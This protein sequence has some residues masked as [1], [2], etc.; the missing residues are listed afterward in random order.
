MPILNPS[1]QAQI[2]P[3]TG[4]PYSKEDL[5]IQDRYKSSLVNKA[6]LSP[7]DTRFSTG[8]TMTLESP[9]ELASYT[10]RGVTLQV[11]GSNEEVRAENQGALEQLGYGTAKMVGLAGTTF[12]DGVLG[13]V[14]GLGSLVTGG[15]FVD[16]PFSNAMLDANEWMEKE[17]PNYYTAEG[18]NAFSGIVPFTQGSANFWGDKILKNFGFALGAYASGLVTAGLSE[19]MLGSKLI[20]GRIS[21]AL[22]DGGKG[23]GE[24]ANILKAIQNGERAGVDYLTDGSKLLQ[25]I[26]NDAKALR[27][28]SIIQQFNGTLGAAVGESRIEALGNAREFEEREISK[29]QQ[30]YGDNI[31]EQELADLDNKVNAYTN[32]EFGVNMAILALSDYA[33]FGQAFKG[34]YAKNKALLGNISGDIESGYNVLKMGK[35]E[36]SA[37]LLKNPIYE[38]TQEQLQYAAQ[39]GSDN[40]YSDRYD[41]NGKKIVNGVVD[42]YVK[43]LSEAYG[44][45]EGWEQFATG[46]IIGSFGMPNIPKITGQKGIIQGGIYGELQDIN[47]QQTNTDKAVSALNQLKDKFANNE[48]LKSHYENLV[49]ISKLEGQQK[50][51]LLRGDEFEY[52]NKEE[53]KFLS[54]V[55]TFYNSGKI[56]DLQDIYEGMSH[57]SAEEIRQ[58]FTV[59]KDEQG[60]P[61]EKPIDPFANLT[62]AELKSYF[63]NRG[64]KALNKIQTIK[65]AKEDID[66][67]FA[68][69]PEAYREE[70]LH[71]AY[72]IDD[73]QKRFDALNSEIK[74]KTG[75][76]SIVTNG[77]DGKFIS[78]PV[79]TPDDPVEFEK[80]VKQEDNYKAFKESVEKHVKKHPEQNELIDKAD[81]LIKL[82][83]R[84]KEFVDKYLDG[85]TKNGK[86][87]MLENILK[88]LKDKL[89]PQIKKAEAT[90]S[91]KEQAIAK[92]YSPNRIDNKSGIFVRFGDNVYT[93]R[94][95]DG[96]RVLY[97][98]VNERVIKDFTDEDSFEDYLVKNPK[99]S[100]L[101]I[102]EYK[103]YFAAQKVAKYRQAE[104]EA[105]KQLISRVTEAGKEKKEQ[106]A[107]KQKELE[108]KIAEVEKLTKDINKA[109]YLTP[110]FRDEL[111]QLVKD[112]EQGIIDLKSEIQ[113]LKEQREE[114]LKYYDEYNSLKKQLEAQQDTYINI[115]KL[116]DE[117]QQNIAEK[118]KNTADELLKQIADLM[119]KLEYYQD[120]HQVIQD[121]ILND[122]ILRDF[123][124]SEDFT[125]A[126]NAKYP[127]KLKARLTPEFMEEYEKLLKK[128][129]YQLSPK[130]L[131]T[132]RQTK[133]L[134]RKNPDYYKDVNSLLQQRAKL[135]ELGQTIKFNEEQLAFTEKEID[136][137]KSVLPQLVAKRE[138]LLNKEYPSSLKLKA[139]DEF[140]KIARKR[141]DAFDKLL[142]QE[143]ADQT[144]KNGLTAKEPGTALDKTKEER[145]R[146][147]MKK[148]SWATTT[149][150][151]IQYKYN[152]T[153]GKYEDILGEDGLP[154]FT[155]SKSQLL[156]AK[157]LDDNSIALTS[158]EYSIEFHL[159]N[160]ADNT[161]LNAQITANIPADKIDVG[162]DIYAV[163]V[164][165]NGKPVT[166][167]GQ[168][169]FTGIH[170][171]ETLFPEEGG[172]RLIRENALIGDKPENAGLANFLDGTTKDPNIINVPYKGVTKTI[173]EWQKEGI[174]DEVLATRKQ[175]IF[176]QSKEEFT[177]YRN[178]V[179]ARLVKGEKVFSQ[180]KSVSDGIPYLD[181][182]LKDAKQFL[183]KDFTL[184]YDS[185]GTFIA[186][187]S[188]GQ[189]IPIEGGKLTD[190][191]INT[192]IE[193][194]KYAFPKGEEHFNGTIKLPKSKEGKQYTQ[195][196]GKD[197][198][199]IF[200]T[201]GGKASVLGSIIYY[202][203]NKEGSKK[204]NIWGKGT[205]IQFVDDAGNTH[206]IKRSDLY[207]PTSQG[208]LDLQS[209]LATKNFNFNR[210]FIRNGLY[211]HPVITDGKVDFKIYKN[212]SDFVKGR[213]KTYIHKTSDEHPLATNRYLTY[214]T[215]LE[216][217]PAETPK[218]P[219]A[220]LGKKLDLSA[221]DMAAEMSEDL[222]PDDLITQQIEAAQKAGK[223]ISGKKEVEGP[224]SDAP[225][226][227]DAVI[228]KKKEEKKGVAEPSVGLDAFGVKEEKTEKKPRFTINRKPTSKERVSSI[229]NEDALKRLKE[230]VQ[231]GQIEKK[232]S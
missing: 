29:L 189:R 60:N 22:A 153:T 13:T 121:I 142:P 166:V 147:N 165:K 223:V 136:R 47:E 167:S 124:S 175:E 53:D 6:N 196:D 9:E 97:D 20:A 229:T 161:G 36:K 73:V 14:V 23:K 220:G 171:I 2:D 66:T 78:E 157:F 155:D 65:K 110:E 27:A 141:I 91:F 39:K 172:V 105:L 104:I 33:Q 86:E 162:N 150:V 8:Q 26:N 183:S 185:T 51:A 132:I 209:F 102:Q 227:I 131:D 10:D 182:T 215:E 203:R 164:D 192:V 68:G 25:A 176:A 41:E 4:L 180:I 79:E 45:A 88:E 232:C 103:E 193:I 42:S 54:N 213:A 226:S 178:G 49:R 69:T 221:E 210:A 115:N 108:K 3:N 174:W 128:K 151:V 99:Y 187:T 231:S 127:D 201:G 34:N 82:A 30:I 129:N 83:Q 145:E 117:E 17:F 28:R 154:L 98:P 87:R 216:D 219:M 202:G 37:R 152:P 194:L 16:N 116:I 188:D 56:E 111:V 122:L 77:P 24:V 204:F 149:G 38:G 76:A 211:F 217:K 21:K 206:I 50:E 186:T 64:Q 200:P 95:I 148:G 138:A 43:G 19:E 144:T 109:K 31:P 48:E 181:K 230:L 212:Y 96:K 177:T 5:L 15:S 222:D 67:K 81:D 197:T 100:V 106:I 75:G 58:L 159:H 92:G 62:N 130:Q 44:T 205:S 123:L 32:T 84:K 170:K 137:I 195:P 63:T 1:A 133:D 125:V 74:L 143:Q 46:A 228:A 93:L 70:L 218:S 119:E 184:D 113:E 207:Q 214:S 118:A 179:K 12:A 52:K 59:T 71:Y 139:F 7:L 90:K 61:L 120:F 18:Q 101:S 72:T 85:L 134:L 135:I 55:I 198:I 57:K 169:L 191:E 190:K 160:N 168:Y 140:K 40:F 94:T 163:I 158:G 173:A 126:F 156:W 114:L 225:V 224:M 107:Q 80:F 11:G 89:E 208:Y 35:F 146:E 199:D 112:L